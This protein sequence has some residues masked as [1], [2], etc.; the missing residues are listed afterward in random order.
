M[1]KSLFISLAIKIGF[2]LIVDKWGVLYNT[3]W[4]VVYHFINHLFVTSMMM[5]CIFYIQNIS[6]HPKVKT[7]KWI[8]EH[9]KFATVI[10]GVTGALFM[11][12]GFIELT[13]LNM[14]WDKYQLGMHQGDFAMP[15]IIYTALS[16]VWYG[17]WMFYLNWKERKF[18]YEN[19]N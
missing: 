6:S 8:L 11:M 1:L 16:F 3:N 17:L 19:C 13:Y 5:F 9:K 15:Q 14:S 12:F 2:D 10:C 18:G 4:K 7:S